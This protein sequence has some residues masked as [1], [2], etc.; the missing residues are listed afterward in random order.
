MYGTNVCTRC[1]VRY[2]APEALRG[3]M[4]VLVLY[5]SETGTARCM[6]LDLCEHLSAGGVG[7][8]CQCVSGV[9]FNGLHTSGVEVVVWLMSTTGQGAPP[10]TWTRGWRWLLQKR[11][12]MSRPWCDMRMAVLGLGDRSYPDYN[13]VARKLNARLVQV[14]AQM[15]T[16]LSLCDAS[17]EGGSGPQYV[18]WRQQVMAALLGSERHVHLLPC[19]PCPFHVVVDDDAG[20]LQQQPQQQQPPDAHDHDGVAPVLEVRRVTA[21]HHWHCVLRMSLGGVRTQPGDTL[22]LYPNNETVQSPPLCVD[23]SAA[24]T[25]QGLL[26]H[27]PRVE[28]ILDW[29]DRHGL[30]DRRVRVA[31]ADGTSAWWSGRVQLL[32]WWLTFV[33]DPFST[34]VPYYCIRVAAHY[35]SHTNPD[36]VDRMRAL[37]SQPFGSGVREYVLEEK[38]SAA[39]VLDE[40]GCRASR[41]PLPILLSALP[42]IYPRPYSVAACGRDSSSILV[43][44]QQAVTPLVRLYCGRMSATLLARPQTLRYFVTPSPL[45]VLSTWTRRPGILVT[46]GT[47]VAAVLPWLTL[48]SQE[49]LPLWSLYHGCRDMELDGMQLNSL[50]APADLAALSIAQSRVPGYPHRYVW[51]ALLADAQRVWNTLWGDGGG[52][53]DGF[54]VVVGSLRMARDVEGALATIAK[55]CGQCSHEEALAMVKAL[56]AK[57][58]TPVS[59]P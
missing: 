36:V 11:L 3:L 41:V 55:Q 23:T 13:V 18:L 15:I 26:I 19:P 33:F 32:S 4:D 56:Q 25:T 10:R 2:Q 8:A 53:N 37:A 42:V 12:T 43:S 5:G 48:N 57:V 52:E 35:S 49:G 47:G 24:T 54:C 31:W 59:A 17:A 9:D 7:A 58:G 39:E 1:H 40:F 45:R 27:R 44:V 28:P 20:C 29:M 22:W 34:A 38:R 14:G 46:A 30:T 21:D 16:P 51:H 50:V 6:A